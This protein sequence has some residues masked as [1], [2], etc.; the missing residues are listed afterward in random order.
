MT[1]VQEA[2]D[3]MGFDLM[4]GETVC[5]S[6]GQER[7]REYS[8]HEVADREIGAN[9]YFST[10]TFPVDTKWG[11]GARDASNVLRVLEFP[12]DFDLKDFLGID[13]ETLVDLPEDELNSYI[14]MLQSAVE[15]IFRQIGLP[16][17]RL[18]FTGYGLSAH[19]KLQHN[20]P[21]H[22]ATIKKYHA[23]IVNEVNA[24]FG[25]TLADPQVKDAGTR[26][27][28]L[29]PCQNVFTYEGG[30]KAAPRISHTIYSRPGALDEA[31]VQTIVE[32]FRHAPKQNVVQL[33]PAAGGNLAK[34][35]VALV[36]DTLNPYWQHGQRHFLALSLGGYF[37]K[38]MIPEE[39]A[40][41]IVTTL[42]D[43]DNDVFDRVRAVRGSY[44]K[45]KRGVE[46]SGY[47]PLAAMIDADDLDEI[48]QVIQAHKKANG[49]RL[50]LNGKPIASG[51]D[52]DDK[53]RPVAFEE[54]PEPPESAMY[55][56]FG[57]Y[58]DLMYPT[59]EATQGFHLATALTVA[60]AIVGRRVSAMYA[61]EHIYPNQ[62]TLLVGPTGS[63]RKGTT[64]K[65]A[66]RLPTYRDPSSQ[67]MHV[68]PYAVIRNVGS[69]ASVVKTLRENPN[70][71]LVLEEATT[72]FNNMHRQGGEELLDRMIEAWDTPDFIQDNVKN[73]PSVAYSPFMSLMAGIQ[74]GRLE[75]ALGG[76]EIESGLANRMGIFFGVRRRVV[77]N[78]PSLDKRAAHDLYHEFNSNV[79]SYGEGHALLM[80]SEASG[81]WDNW[82]IQ[83]SSLK[84]SEDELAMR[85]RHPDMV[86]KWALLF[87]IS[88]R[89][90]AIRVPHL[91]AAL[92]ILTWMW[93]GIKRRLPT[94]GVSIDRKIEELIRQNLMK[95]GAMKRRD[96]Q[97][98]CSR[99]KW[100]GREFA[101]VFRAMVENGHLT[102]DSVGHVALSSHVEAAQEAARKE[103]A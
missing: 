22:Y 80:D 101:M 92:A 2:F 19:V 37:A 44:D 12:F 93:E 52:V 48:D 47:Y 55:G 97:I 75:D 59:T 86:I 29:V 17:H 79:L 7:F 99:R 8:L 36:V 90:S 49:P 95:H 20:G 23:A 76:N 53:D 34:E 74:P 11:K 4:D 13:K 30:T 73:N 50:V 61:S 96:L 60:G 77:A 26:I 63:S 24:L 3:A 41:A 72:L 69:G 82:Y 57:R 51:T 98:A 18:D 1:T 46:V 68:P 31:S 100:S 85:I 25:G 15:G 42:S 27:M 28:R 43:G 88:D 78:P 32:G 21:E 64:M 33:Y 54:Y 10:G 6:F 56:W 84:G 83:Y 35:G 87:A 39:Q 91:E 102:T 81:Y 71:L 5:I 66:H 103:T 16:I 38:N 9:V 40:V 70:T 67:T 65:R 14:P 89:D 58:V 94:W 45:A 62:Y